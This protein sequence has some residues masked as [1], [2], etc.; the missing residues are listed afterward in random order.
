MLPNP[1]KAYDVIIV[2]TGFGG[3]VCAARLAEMGL[4]VF[5]LERGRW[6][7]GAERQ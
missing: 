3:S 7:R 1:A 2:G 4:R 6:W 5:V